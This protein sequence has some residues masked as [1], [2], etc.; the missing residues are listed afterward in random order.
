MDLTESVAP[1]SDQ[2]ERWRAVPGHEGAYEVS[3]LGRVRSINR[4][5][6]RG[7]RIKGRVLSLASHR[8]G[9]QQVNLH[10]GRTQAT[11]LVHQLVTLAFV[12]PVPEGMEVR[13]LNG[14]RSDNTLP[15]LA[16]GTH[17]DNMRDQRAH[18]THRNSLKANCP[19]GHPYAGEN[20]MVDKHGNR[21][22]AKCRRESWRRVSARRSANRKAA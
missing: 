3:D 1:K 19:A 18:G 14:V 5:T 9:Y 15:N 21:R 10:R 8:N 2:L 13:H 7:R 6:D 12:G 22:C 20:L 4:I 16:Y 17:L 11:H